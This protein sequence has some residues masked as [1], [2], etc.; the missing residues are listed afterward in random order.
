M[1]RTLIDIDVPDLT[2][3]LALVTGASDGLGLVLAERL[4]RAGADLVLPVRNPAKGAAAADRIRAAAPR[5]AI[6]VPRLDLSSLGSV[7]AL[8]DE[9]L[10]DGRPIDILINN[11]GIMTPPERRESEDGFELQL[12]TNHLGHYALTARIL[13][14]LRA[15]N[16]RVTTQASVAANQ[17][18]V[19]WDDLQWERSY[20]KDKAYASSK[21]AIGLFGL[22]LD[23]VSRAR[24]W[25]ITS[26]VAHPGVSATN[27][28]ASHPEMGREQDTL[29]VRVIRRV[30]TSR[31]PFGQTAA[32]GALPALYAATSSDAQGGRFYGPSGPMQLAGKPVQRT[33]Y[34]HLAG[35]Q[36]AERM[37]RLSEQ[38]TGVSWDSA[39]AERRG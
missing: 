19:H 16:A 14:L 25:G 36:D 22:Q 21:I 27:L 31:L 34:K 3:K 33:P 2:G 35:E 28:L 26:N 29:A 10:A 15:A 6:A 1:P 18:G 17:H 23:R 24:G 12:A 20:N 32:E 4:A 11:A 5:A 9:L 38:L 8:A 30:A 39:V 7:A 13:P 37:W